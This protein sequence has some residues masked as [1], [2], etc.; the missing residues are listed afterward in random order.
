MNAVAVSKCDARTLTHREHGNRGGLRL[1]VRQV[2]APRVQA[3][4]PHPHQPAILLVQ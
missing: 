1:E 4:D 3:T 2:L